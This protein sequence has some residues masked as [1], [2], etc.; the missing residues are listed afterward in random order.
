MRKKIREGCGQGGGGGRQ[1]DWESEEEGI[2]RGQRGN[3][4]EGIKFVR[5]GWDGGRSVRSHIERG[6]AGPMGGGLGEG[7]KGVGGRVG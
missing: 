2:G 4:E 1:E 7:G 3:Q 6:Y 5:E